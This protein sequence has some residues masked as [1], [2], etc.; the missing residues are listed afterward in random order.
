MRGTGGTQAV[1][2]VH[3]MEAGALGRVSVSPK[4]LDGGAHGGVDG[5]DAEAEFLLGVGA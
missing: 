5:D 3:A 4:P 2:T 1:W